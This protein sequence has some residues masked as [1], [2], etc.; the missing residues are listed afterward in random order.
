LSLVTHWPQA[1]RQL[2]AKRITTVTETYLQKRNDTLLCRQIISYLFIR[3]VPC[4]AT[5]L[6]FESVA[7]QRLPKHIDPVSDQ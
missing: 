3:L 2:N 6:G 5:P 7:R 1:G 4:M